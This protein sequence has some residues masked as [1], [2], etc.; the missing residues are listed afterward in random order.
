MRKGSLHIRLY[1]LDPTTC[2]GVIV[3]VHNCY[4]PRIKVTL[5]YRHFV[6][7]LTEIEGKIS[8]MKEV[9]SEPLF[10]ILLFV[11]R[12]NNQSVIIMVG[13][14]FRN[15]PKD[16]HTTNLNHWLWFELAFFTDS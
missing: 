5:L 14:L 9:V 7:T 3:C 4:H 15:V 6:L 13:V 16:R 10:D 12:V 8:V 11:V 1:V 2:H